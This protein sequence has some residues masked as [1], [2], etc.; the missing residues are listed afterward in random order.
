MRYNL[1]MNTIMLQHSAGLDRLATRYVWW[2]S[3]EWA[4]AHPNI[5][6]SNVMN[7]G[8]WDDI[9]ILRMMVTD[10]ILRQVL[11]NAPPGSF[12]PR[13]WDYWHVK[14]AIKPISPLPK[15]NY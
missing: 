6:L 14:L 12:Y 3:T 15:R 8:H 7:L 10:Y 13:S 1:K 5:F 2:E 11:Q 4:Y 9:Q